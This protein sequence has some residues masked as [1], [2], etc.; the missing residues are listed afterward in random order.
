MK[1][2]P[3]VSNTF[4]SDGGAMFG[5]VPKGIWQR[6][7]PPDENNLIPQRAN[8]W[9]IETDDG[10]TGLLESGCGDPEWFSARERDLH[11]LEEKWLLPD[12]LQKR[13]VDFEKIDFVILSHAHWDH[14][15]GLMDPEG[16]PVFPNAEIFLRQA[17]V[18]C[19]LGG[20]PLLY[21]SYPEKIQKS[22]SIL[23]DRIFPVPDE[24]PEMLPG[25]YLLPAPGHSEGQAAVFF[26]STE[27]SGREGIR[28][29]AVF[30]G[31]NCPSQHHLRMV[32]Q[33]AYDT[34]PLKTRAWKQKWLPR[35][36]EDE[37]LLMFTHDPH[38]FAAW[39]AKDEKR[40]FVVQTAYTGEA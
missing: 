4:A 12:S 25:L 31:D 20:D 29:A 21:K 3:L 39:I 27:V 34:F 33:S 18:D 13:G 22:F 19:V 14:A 38:M 32:F 15:G 8:S 30:P 9:L 10:K 36:A 26:A 1:I 6:L 5:L 16:R 24:E 23:R 37:L 28:T 17:E 40:E 35:C 2:T 11:R 7:C